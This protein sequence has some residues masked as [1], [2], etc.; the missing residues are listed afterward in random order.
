MASCSKSFSCDYMLLDPSDVGF[1][2]LLHILFSS[3][4]KRR[5]FVH[6]SMDTE[7]DRDRRWLIFLSIVVQKLL[8][9]VATPMAMIGRGIEICLNLFS[10]TQNL[11][12]LFKNLLRGIYNLLPLHA[13][14]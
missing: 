13:C 11:V 5:R 8:L 9:F 1:F 12:G 4:L 2:D 3:S 6:S 10:S 7:D 14:S